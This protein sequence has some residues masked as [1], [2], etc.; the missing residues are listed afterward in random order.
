[1]RIAY[2]T[3]S[4]EVT[5]IDYYRVLGPASYAGVE[6]TKVVPHDLIKP[7]EALGLFDLFYISRESVKYSRECETI[8]SI[9]HE[10]NKPCV[11][12]LDDALFDLP[13]NHPDYI[14]G[15]YAH[16][17]ISFLNIL[18]KVDA[19][20]VPTEKLAEILRTIT[21]TPI[22]ILP[23]LFDDELW[24]IEPHRPVPDDGQ[25]TLLFFGSPSHIIDLPIILGVLKEIHTKYLNK[26]SFVFYGIP[27][28][29]DMPI[30]FPLTQLPSETYIYASF[31]E[32]IKRIKADVGL[33]PLSDSIFNRSKSSIKYFEYTA[34][35]LPTIASN[36]EPYQAVINDGV[37]GLLASTPQD[38][39]ESIIRVIESS[40]FRQDLVN[41][42]QS[43]LK[44]YLMRNNVD[45]WLSSI[46]NFQY[47]P[48]SPS[49][50][51]I[52]SQEFI[53]R[54]ADQI[55]N[56]MLAHKTRT[57]HLELELQKTLTQNAN[58]MAEKR[59]LDA[60]RLELEMAIE[61]IKASNS[62]KL[63]RP[64]R[65]IAKWIKK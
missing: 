56:N 50:E 41:C 23:N 27:L 61:E 36:L 65:S 13:E 44:K 12:D 19:V 42:A 3:Q 1:M 45:N 33:A 22:H 11:L 53:H 9:A 16:S 21:K 29:A 26:V 64:L 17:L 7:S 40:I 38:W 25:L 15:A 39:V 51:V 48:K 24:G 20:T 62:W 37:N 49:P 35:G 55:Q 14:S 10:K 59:F 31:P 32:K 6:V 46:S 47:L 60:Q 4:P 18:P 43:N 52:F 30:N 54:L 2:F 63:T 58:Y 8:I 57:D 28:P 34:M 5:A